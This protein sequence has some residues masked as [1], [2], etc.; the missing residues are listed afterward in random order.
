MEEAGA[1]EVEFVEGEG[2]VEE[3]LEGLAGEG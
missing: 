1:R 2:L 3:G